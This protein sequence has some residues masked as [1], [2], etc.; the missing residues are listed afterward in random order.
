M[1]ALED[2]RDERFRDHAE[3]SCTKKTVWSHSR[4]EVT[5]GRLTSRS[6]E[7]SDWLI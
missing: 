7:A 3:T 1:P 5:T 4:Y 2:A 6:R